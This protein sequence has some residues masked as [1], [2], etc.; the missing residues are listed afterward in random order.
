MREKGPDV[1]VLI[2]TMQRDQVVVTEVQVNPDAMQR[3]MSSPD[4]M[5]EQWSE[6]R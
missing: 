5:A 1:T 6:V 2:A 3:W 4:K